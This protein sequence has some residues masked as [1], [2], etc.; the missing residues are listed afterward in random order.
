MIFYL[1]YIAI[2]NTY[3]LYSK[4]PN[5]AK[6]SIVNFQLNIAQDTLHNLSLSNYSTRGAQSQSECSTRLQTKHWAYFLEHI[7]S[8][9]NNEHPVERC[10]VR[11]KNNITD[12]RD[13]LAV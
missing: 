12:T 10:H 13:N 1:L 7:P 6:Q 5:S 9:D 11:V 3:V 8:T 4:L 2:Y